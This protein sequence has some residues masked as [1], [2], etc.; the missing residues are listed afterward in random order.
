MQLKNRRKQ[1]TDHSPLNT[2]TEQRIK[3]NTQKENTEDENTF[4]YIHRETFIYLFAVFVDVLFK[5][6]MKIPICCNET[7]GR[8]I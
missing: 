7:G 3:N 4:T 8:F 1:Q 6:C 2:E 5:R